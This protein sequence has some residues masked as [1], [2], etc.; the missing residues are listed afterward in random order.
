M[1]IQY[2]YKAV[3]RAASYVTLNQ[4]N[5]YYAPVEDALETELDAVVRNK[6]FQYF[7]IM[8]AQV[9]AIG[10]TLVHRV[11]CRCNKQTYLTA[12]EVMLYD[13][14]GLGCG[15]MLCPFVSVWARI[16]SRAE[17]ALALQ[18]A[19]A[20]ARKLVPTHHE[21]YGRTP[22][23]V[24]EYL[25]KHRKNQFKDFDFWAVIG[26]G[27]TFVT[28]FL[29]KTRKFSDLPDKELFPRDTIMVNVE[30]D[31]I[32]LAEFAVSF[33]VVEE[34]ALLHRVKYLDKELVDK[35]VVRG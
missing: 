6:K 4:L 23:E 7:S 26:K 3:Q 29:L 17:Y 28:Q 14:A 24:G 10:T 22:I 13:E 32:P 12:K 16:W 34:A 35:L 9:K 31:I 5:P 19:Q 15:D 21:L 1:R 30:G 2:A 25:V 18:W 20:C 33:E 27:N 11:K 8:N